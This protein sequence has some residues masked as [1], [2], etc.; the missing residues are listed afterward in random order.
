MSESIARA[1]FTAQ[2]CAFALQYSAFTN[3]RRD[4]TRHGLLIFP[5]KTVAAPGGGEYRY[6]HIVEM[7]LHLA[8]SA[9]RLGAGKA[10]MWG[11]SRELQS[12]GTRI[13]NAMDDATRHAIY[14]GGSGFE[15]DDYPDS[16]PRDLGALVDFPSVYF[17]PD[18]ISRDADKPTFLLFE[19]VSHK[20][21]PAKI[22]LSDNVE[23]AGAQKKLIAQAA[24]TSGSAE[25]LASMEE[26]F[27]FVPAINLTSMLI[28][29][30][31][32][33]ALRLKARAIRGA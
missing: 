29:L 11:L 2:D 21:Q 17:G 25:H 22:L 6:P 10:V 27:D 8:L 32:R 23:L 26:V 7:A 3:F 9:F 5:R 12:Q 20:D 4:L 30:D 16:A 31:E 19:P 13:I 18:I 33:L 24:A 28:R 15:D 14:F 1:T